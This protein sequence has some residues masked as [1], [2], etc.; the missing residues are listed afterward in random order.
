MWC[1]KSDQEVMKLNGL[2]HVQKYQE[3]VIESSD[4]MHS[5]FPLTKARP[6]LF[7]DKPRDSVTPTVIEVGPKRAVTRRTP[8]TVNRH[9]RFN[10]L[11]H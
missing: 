4:E 5:V 10:S 3:S 8:T 11:I 6:R 2:E 7:W 1:R 9:A